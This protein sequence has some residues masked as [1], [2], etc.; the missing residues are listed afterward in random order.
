MKNCRMSMTST[1]HNPEWAA[2]TTLSNPTASSVCQRS[3]PD[4]TAAILHAARFTVAMMEQL[5]QNPRYT[6]RKPRTAL[7]ALPDYRSS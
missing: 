1:L 6:A 3:N 4:S 2:N 7:A 5:K